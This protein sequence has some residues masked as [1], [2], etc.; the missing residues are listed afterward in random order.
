MSDQHVE[1]SLCDVAVGSIVNA[2]LDQTGK[3]LEHSI[4]AGHGCEMYSIETKDLLEICNGNQ[5]MLQGLKTA[6]GLMEHMHSHR[7]DVA[8]EA[9]TKLHQESDL[10]VHPRPKEDLGGEKPNEV[11]LKKYQPQPVKT[12][13]KALGSLSM[14]RCGQKASKLLNT[15]LPDKQKPLESAAKSVGEK[16]SA[17]LST[18]NMDYIKTK[19]AAADALTEQPHAGSEQE[20]SQMLQ[21]R[22]NH[23]ELRNEGAA[24]WG[25]DEDGEDARS[26]ADDC[27]MHTEPR[28]IEPTLPGEIR[29]SVCLPRRLQQDLTHALQY[30]CLSV[31]QLLT[32]VRVRATQNLQVDTSRQVAKMIRRMMR[33][34]LLLSG[35]RLGSMRLWQ[36]TWTWTYY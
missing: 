34:E 29:S 13:S 14:S 31:L 2:A 27:Y 12:W 11:M 23:H 33:I 18:H 19:H 7:Q 10:L 24:L 4:I 9:H 28:R 26:D 25:V 6:C 20:M 30:L 17:A 21:S 22:G 5:A 15:Q 8:R 1:V 16:R 32:R 36:L 35:T 3:P